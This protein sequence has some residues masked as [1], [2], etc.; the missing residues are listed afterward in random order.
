M[1]DIC[2]VIQ[3]GKQAETEAK[4]NVNSFLGASSTAARATFTMWTLARLTAD[5]PRPTILLKAKLYYLSMKL[6]FIFG[7]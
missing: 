3:D 7:L 6:K 2:D 5:T 4:G 1:T